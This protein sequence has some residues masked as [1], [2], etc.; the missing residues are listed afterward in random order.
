MLHFTMFN[1]SDLPVPL[2]QW[3]LSQVFGLIALVLV[4][5]GFQLKDKSKLLIFIALASVAGSI[6]QTLLTNYIMAAIGAVVVVRLFVYAWL[7]K[8]RKTIPQWLD[9]TILTIFLLVNI[10]ITIFTA[11]WWFDWVFFGFVTV[12]T[13]GQWVSNSH[14]VRVSTMPITIMILIAAIFF[15]N[16]MS[17]LTET[18]VLVS[19][20][21]FYIRFFKEKNR[22]NIQP[23]ACQT[24]TVLTSCA[25]PSTTE[26]GDITVSLVDL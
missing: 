3:I 20:T 26:E 21:I 16:I 9:I 12:G 15:S 13:F 18:F 8:H 19:V 6:M 5:I 4:I 1:F 10:P 17:L 11:E 7:Q 24:E 14:S 22:P 2:W 25:P 23:E